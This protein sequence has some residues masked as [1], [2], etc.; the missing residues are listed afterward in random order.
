MHGTPIR[1][2]GGGGHCAA[3]GRD[4]PPHRHDCWELVLYRSG[5][6]Q[7]VV[8]GEARDASAGLVWLTPP[9]LV[10]AERALTAYANWY[11]VIAA[12]P[13][14]PWPRVARDD[15]DGALER[16]CA[17]I[18]RELHRDGPDRVAM[19]ACLAGELDLRLRRL[20]SG[21]GRRPL[22]AEAVSLLEQ[23]ERPPSIAALARRLGVAPSTLRAAFHRER[24]AAPAAVWR[25][26]RLRRAA[27]LLAHTD[28]TLAAV[29]AQCG[30]H[31]PSHL[32][33]WIV[34]R[35]G[36]APGRL[37]AVRPLS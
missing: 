26:Q 30:F 4:M 11:V 1:I 22:V 16:L 27:A 5:R 18:V 21:A 20:G 32:S 8:E 19:L 24:G 29:A 36:C 35:H 33:R 23:A 10:H 34:R 17:A 7:F 31:S 13:G 15:A 2:I 9:G 12:P 6:P 14:Q 25:E 3:R 37:R 28:L